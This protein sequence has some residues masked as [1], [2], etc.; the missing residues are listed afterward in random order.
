MTTFYD[1]TVNC[2]CCNENV[3]IRRL[4]STNSL[5]GKYTDFHEQTIGDAPIP[6]LM[7]T[8]P[9]CGF[10]GYA[11]DFESPLDE[12][13]KSQICTVISPL[14]QLETLN[15]GRR[16]ELYAEIRKLVGDNIWELANIY[17][18]GAWA[19]FDEGTA[20]EAYLRR[21]A[22]DHFR[23]ALAQNLVPVEQEALITYLIG[24]LYRR[25]GELDAAHT[26]FNKVILRAETDES[27]QEIARFA[28]QQRD[29]P[30]QMFG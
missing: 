22:L 16:Y 9:N 23:E 6:I 3:K 7:N 24:E 10:S 13:L 5:G 17:L 19:A 1:I 4:M 21:L 27:W 14:C 8:C 15:A 12:N 20:N 29:N 2:P 25:I 28:T 30:K 11:K 18:E 26:W